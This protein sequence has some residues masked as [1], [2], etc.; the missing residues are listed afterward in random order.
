MS[1]KK[2]KRITLTGTKLKT[3]EEAMGCLAAIR[4]RHIEHAALVTDRERAV[5]E[6]EQ[7]YADSIEATKT[8]LDQLTADLREWA[9]NNPTTFGQLRSVEW[10]HGRFGWRI[11]PPKL[12]KKSKQPWDDLTPAVRENLGPKYVRVQE[13]VNR[14]RI[15][16]DRE[17]IEPAKLRVCG[18]SVVQE[19]S[20]FVE[21]KVED[22]TPKPTT[23]T[24]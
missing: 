21:P 23:T 17:N 20:F 6:V 11:S 14:E 4:A 16:A 19:E 2:T 12:V 18:L 15:I 13:S 5:L 3:P 9:D 1:S 24:A 8:D 10:T 22:T 7:K